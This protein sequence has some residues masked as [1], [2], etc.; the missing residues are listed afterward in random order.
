MQRQAFPIII[1]LVALAVAVWA[2][3][4]VAAAPPPPAIVT[5]LDAGWPDVR[6]WDA[7]G[8]L[9][10]QWAPW[11]EWPLVFAP[12][13]TYQNGVRV[14]VGDV[15]GDGHA[16]IVTA[17][18]RSAF[19]ELKVFDGRSFRQLGTFL[20]FKDASWWEGAYI[21][22][23]DTDG[24]GRAEV[25]EGLGAG[26]CTT[27]H[28]LD[29]ETGNDLSGFFPYGDRSDVGARVASADVNADGKAEILAVPLGG[30]RVSAFARSGGA[31]FRSLEAF[32]SDAVGGTSIAAGNLVG[33]SRAEVV[34]A[35]PT[36]SGA[37][38]KIIDVTT[39]ATRASFFPYGTQAVSSLEVALGDVDGD[40]ALDI[41]LSAVTS[42]GTQVKA[43]DTSGS[44]LA[45][46][47]VLDP[48]IVPG[49][50]IAAG[51]LDGDGKAEIVLGGGPTTAP[52]PPVANG[53][54]QRVA[55]YEPDGTPVGGFSAYPGLFQGGVRVA[56]AD[57]NQDRRP[58][59][60]TAPGKGMQAEIGVFT[61]QWVNGRNRGTRLR[62]FLA[63]ESS[64]IG[65]ASVA[66]GDVNGDGEAEIV[67]AAGPGRAPE[68]RVFDAS[69]RQ[70]LSFLAFGSDYTGGLS[71]AAG[72]LNG[73][74]RAEIVTGTLARPAR[75]RTF[76]GGIPFGPVVAPF[77]PDRPGVEVGVADLA[78]DGHGVILAGS[79]SGDRPQLAV[80]DPLSGSVL[81]TVAVD[82]DLQN[83][84][85][86]AGGDL[87]GD[88]RDEIVVTPGF[89]GDSRVRIFD[90]Q[91]VESRSFAA[92][93]WAG[94]GMNVA[95]ATRIGLP[96]AA[97][98]RTVRLKA[99]KRVRIVVAR[100]R[101]AAG[102]SDAAGLRAEIIWG[103]GTSWNGKVLSRG[104]GLYDVRSVKRYARAGRYWVI[105]TLSD[106][107]GRT[108][109][110]RSTA[111]V[112][113]R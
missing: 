37:H 85:R 1:V 36:S 4:V 80:V 34:A 78:G 108:S 32:G 79:A 35:A 27:L 100:F 74:G 45:D 44:Q 55:V 7:T 54:D 65:G 43:V 2:A 52:W 6:G 53:P 91:L 46:F 64:F 61:Q 89:G 29:A 60:V 49:A 73:D 96:I 22:T 8:N 31:P 51:D 95:L 106:S 62:H 90:R 107:R 26:C 83:G 109:I 18:G 3:E 105:V 15:N 102:S 112:A 13:P 86:V 9:A 20:P 92:Y 10:R 99:R 21:A 70:L 30:G 88:G 59:L 98:P 47:Y 41:V 42:G 103:D 48:A 14:A 72:D 82:D 101:D 24:D 76:D 40:G 57:L 75:I 58:E 63:F 19:T 87:D 56:L 104:G 111:I 97:Q 25:V 67:A 12:Y 93:D 69:G 38:V 33:D 113:R 94:A 5:G 84:I 81:R 110:A 28:V 50:S 71:V 23:G 39:G 17:P 68:V 16:E 66:T 77:A 11:G